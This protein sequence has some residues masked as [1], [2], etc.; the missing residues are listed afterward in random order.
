MA[1]TYVILPALQT[2]VCARKYDFMIHRAQHSSNPFLGTPGG[3][4][5]SPLPSVT[6]LVVQN[7]NYTC[8]S[9][10]ACPQKRYEI[11]NFIFPEGV[12]KDH[13]TLMHRQGI[14][15]YFQAEDK[16][17]V[18][19]ERP[20][21]W[22]QLREESKGEKR[23]GRKHEWRGYSASMASE[24]FLHCWRRERNIPRGAGRG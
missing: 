12:F 7:F 6:H 13:S 11:R 15:E 22:E 20:K 10:C 4:W 8:Y 2:C 19:T 9:I 17:S 18:K 16:V 1:S 3:G 14:W 24:L 21:R 23:Q 5:F